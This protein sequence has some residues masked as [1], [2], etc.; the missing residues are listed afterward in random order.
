MANRVP[1]ELAEFA[2]PHDDSAHRLPTLPR[3]SLLTLLIVMA[4]IS[5]LFAVMQRI[6][7]AGS[8]L[9]VWGLLL[10]AAHVLANAWG[11]RRRSRQALENQSSPAP[12]PWQ[13]VPTSAHAPAT[14]LR[15]P[16]GISKVMFVFSVVGALCGGTLGGIV[17]A[18]QY[19][20]Q[21]GT[22]PVALGAISAAIL[23][24]FFGFLISS[25][26]QVASRAW[27]EAATESRR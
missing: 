22:L 8:V 19:W 14:R 25:F 16:T 10:I 24:G 26:V 1:P 4:S 7:T 3:F 9:L 23:G 21:A 27:N 20:H 18:T 17:L 6:G 12:T 2:E 13:P 11:S 5:V 15:E